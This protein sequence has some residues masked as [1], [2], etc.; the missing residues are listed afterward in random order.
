MGEAV[1]AFANFNI[2]PSFFV[3]LVPEV[4]VDDDLFGDDVLSEA[5]VFRIGHRSVEVEVGQVNAEEHGAR[6]ADC[7][8]D[9]E[10]GGEKIRSGS[11]L[12]AGKVDEVTA[13][14]ESNAVDLLLLRADVADDAAVRRAVASRIL[15]VAVI[16]GTGTAWWLNLKVSVMRSPPVSA[17]KTRMQR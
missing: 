14:S 12:I 16:L 10:F 13:D 2:D 6:G 5:H 4:A 17:I 1:H 15:S 8:V 11:A 7:G 3:G 9:E